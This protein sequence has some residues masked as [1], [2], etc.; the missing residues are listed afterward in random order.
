VGPVLTAIEAS[1]NN[2]TQVTV[3]GK[4]LANASIYFGDELASALP[5]WP[6]LA[7][8]DTTVTG[9]VPSGLGQT[10]VWAL[11]PDLGYDKLT[12]AFTWSTP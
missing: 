6:V 11:D 7:R 12:F 4:N 3:R 2:S 10:T 9:I 1:P 8:T 5:L